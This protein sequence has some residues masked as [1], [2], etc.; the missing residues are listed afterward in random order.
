MKSN[1]RTKKLTE[2]QFEQTVKKLRS[3]LSGLAKRRSSGRVSADD[4]HSYLDKQGIKT[5]QVNTRLSFINTV[6]REPMFYCAG[7]KKSSRPAAK[8]RSITEWTVS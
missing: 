7:V 8:G 3:W 6:L 5:A 1:S 4:V 2:A